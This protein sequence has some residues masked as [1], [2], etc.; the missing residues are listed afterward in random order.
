MTKISIIANWKCNPALAV[1]AKNLFKSADGVVRNAKNVEVVIC[2]P[3]VYLSEL[4]N[5]PK[6]QGSG[7]A[8]GAQDCFWEQKGAY[9]GEVSPVM[10]KNLGCK[11]VIVGHS[12]RRKYFNE[13]NESVNKKIKAAFEA[14]LKPI[15]CVG[16]KHDEKEII[17]EVLE[18]QLF[19]GL[20]GVSA[21][22][23]S[24]LIIAYEP[25]WAISSEEGE[26]CSPEYAFS[27]NLIIKKFLFKEY[28]KTVADKARIIYGGS[29]DGKD[30]GLYI[31]EGKLAG[32]LVGKASLNAME[33]GKIIKSMD[34]ISS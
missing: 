15:F 10:L 8:L 3:F 9:T 1:E 20:A 12:E 30:A 16:E 13:T 4:K 22:K 11:Y 23:I 26:Y 6:D 28:D 17:K 32:V 29:V 18:K 31:K 5:G 14:G 24:D 19:E 2:S 21:S 25:V 34:A 33:F 27:A 7:V